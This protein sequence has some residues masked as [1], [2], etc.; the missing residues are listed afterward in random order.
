MCSD[1]QQRAC[2]NPKQFLVFSLLEVGMSSTSMP[3]SLAS[4]I[5]GSGSPWEVDIWCQIDLCSEAFSFPNILTSS[6][7][8]WDLAQELLVSMTPANI[9]DKPFS[10]ISNG[11][12]I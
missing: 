9:L 11:S 6:E 10:C 12:F 3:A 1:F 5:V 8:R 2:L 4:Y 7:C